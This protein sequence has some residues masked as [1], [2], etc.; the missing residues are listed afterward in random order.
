MPRGLQSLIFGHD[1]NQ[2]LEGVHLPDGLKHLVFGDSFDQSLETVD[3]PSGLE[4]LTL[5]EGF[6]CDETSMLG[7]LPKGL[8]HLTCNRKF[9]NNVCLDY[10]HLPEIG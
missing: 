4:S 8:K 2:S 10:F 7:T 1:F 3:F 5:G 6:G 9:V